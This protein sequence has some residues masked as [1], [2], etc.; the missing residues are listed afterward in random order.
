MKVIQ[1][2]GTNA[3]G[4]TTAVRQFIERGAFEV[5]SIPVNGQEIEYHYDPGRGIAVLG[6]YD[7]RVSGGIDGD[8]TNKVVLRNSIVKLCRKIQ[9]KVLIFEGIVYGVTFKFAYELYQALKLLGYEYR[10]ICFIPPLEVAFDRLAERNGGK[11]VDVL[12]VQNKWFTAA[13]SAEKLKQAG[14]PVKIVDTSKVEKGDMWK[15]IQE[16]ING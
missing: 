8:I 3:T 5:R 1:L 6:R 10:A 14:I 16:A 11:P 7:T 2:R 9:P 12:S 15:I 13:R 4:K